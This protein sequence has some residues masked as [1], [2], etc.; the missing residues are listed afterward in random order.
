MLSAPHEPL[1]VADWERVLMIHYEVEALALQRVVPFELEMHDGRAFVS[2]VAFTMRGMRPRFGGRLG[3]W[4][5]RPIA[6]HGFLNVRTY[7]RNGNEAGI[8][9]L[10]E[11]LSNRLSLA[12]GPYLFGLPYRLGRLE[13]GRGWERPPAGVSTCEIALSGY[14]EDLADNGVLAYRAVLEGSVGFGPCEP[15]SIAEWLMERYTAFTY[16]AGKARLFR[17]WHPPWSQVRAK[18]VVSEPGLLTANWPFFRDAQIIGSNFSP[19][20]RGVWMGRPHK[21]PVCRSAILQLSANVKT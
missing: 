16:A 12:L 9:F 4:L 20:V 2:F 11:W 5:L 19:G 17:V 14:V 18:V 7:V 1:F 6:T 15:G 8:Y 3:A 13:Y 10:A 21:L